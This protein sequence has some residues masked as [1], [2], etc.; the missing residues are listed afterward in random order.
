MRIYYINKK[1]QSEGFHDIHTSDCTYLPDA[2]YKQYLGVFT[3]CK[4]ALQGAKTLFTKVNGCPYCIKECY[5][6]GGYGKP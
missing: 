2:E 3:H 1:E 5:R 4:H 6:E